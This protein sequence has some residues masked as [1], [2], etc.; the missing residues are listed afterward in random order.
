MYQ[1]RIQTLGSVLFP[2]IASLAGLTL[3]LMVSPVMAAQQQNSPFEFGPGTNQ[4]HSHYRTLTV[5]AKTSVNVAVQLQR[6]A[7]GADVPVVIEVRQASAESVGTTGPDGPLIASKNATAATGMQTVAFQ[8]QSFSSQ[9]GCPSTWRVRVRTANSQR[10][11]VK[12]FGTIVYLYNPPGP[13]NLDMEGGTLSLNAGA[14]ATRALAGTSGG[15]IAGTGTFRIRAKWH[16]DPLD[17]AHLNSYFRLTVS[18]IRP[19]GTVAASEAG[20]SQHAPS[21]RTPKVNFTYLVTAQ[22]ALMSGAWS[23]RVLNNSSVKIVDFDIEKGLD[24]NPLMPNFKSTFAAGC[25]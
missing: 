12:V 20:F 7:G 22:D 15:V 14:T 5:P 6:D 16:T 11:P 13:V 18:L 23:L 10:P 17:L 25:N 2:K 24:L 1:P 4:D 3:A 8:N 9:F 21:D 19:N